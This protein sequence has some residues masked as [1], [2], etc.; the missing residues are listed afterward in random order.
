MKRKN[1]SFITGLVCSCIVLCLIAGFLYAGRTVE[2]KDGVYNPVSE[3]A[4]LSSR[5]TPSVA[6]NQDRRVCL[7]PNPDNM[8]QNMEI[9]YE[10][11]RNL[12]YG[13]VLKLDTEK[14][15]GKQLRFAV[16]EDNRLKALD[17]FG[18]L[19]WGICQGDIFTYDEGK[20]TAKEGVL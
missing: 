7:L 5:I 13:R 20:F 9:T 8:D 19:G 12:K 10:T 6:L 1:F 3:R 18:A 4:M 14:L 15:D 11:E 16:L 2:T 17:T